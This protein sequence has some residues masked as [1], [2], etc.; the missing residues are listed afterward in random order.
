MDTLL[1]KTKYSNIFGHFV[2]LL[3]SVG[4]SG[5]LLGCTNNESF[6]YLNVTSKKDGIYEIYRIDSESPLQFVSEQIGYFN[7]KVELIPGA[8]LVLADCSSETVI[9]HPRTLKKLT[10]HQL[11][12]LPPISPSNDDK[13]SIQCNRYSKTMFRQNLTNRYSFNILEGKRE[14]LVGMVPWEVDFSKIS[15]TEEVKE[16]TYKLAAI[17]VINYENM[18]PKTSYFVSPLG[19]LI[20][21][22]EPQEFGNWQL[23]LPGTYIV[24]VNGTKLNVKLEEG[25]TRSISPAFLKTSTPPNVKYELSSQIVGTP[26]YLEL[27]QYHWL[28]LNETYPA[29]PGIANLRLNGSSNSIAVE[30]EEDELFNLN[31]YSVQV[32]DDCSPWEWS[33]LGGRQIFLYE[34][35]SAYPFSESVTDI[36]ILFFNRDAWIGIQGSKDIRYKIDTTNASQTYKIGKAKFIPTPILRPGHVTDLARV[37]AIT[38]FTTGHTLDIRLDEETVL[39]LISGDYAF[40]QYVSSLSNEQERQRTRQKINIK[41][42]KTTILPFSVF[43]TEKKYNF[44]KAAH[45]KMQ[46]FTKKKEEM[47]YIRYYH[48]PIA[49]KANK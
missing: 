40:A 43:V 13:F 46:M 7:K 18:P 10:A 11:T 20:S 28:D 17:Q 5:F 3:L 45:Q 35:D 36:P 4:I 22:T 48:P 47:K 37:E 15:S 2:L 27:N 42:G 30:L 24:E 34:K 38:S 16:L 9:I 44:L 39:P 32:N 41:P 26:L 21:V 14:L 25:E 33:C 1:I 31:V 8:Y 23:L 19:G 6:G 49:I 12:F 29:L